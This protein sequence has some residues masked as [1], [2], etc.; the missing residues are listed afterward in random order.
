MVRA[1][2][3]AAGVEAGAFADP[4]RAYPACADDPVVSPRGGDWATAELRC[5]A[6]AWVRA[7]RTGAD[8]AA[9]VA[10]KGDMPATGPEVVTLLRSLA[11]GAMITQADVAL[12]PMSERGAEDIF[13][14]PSAVIGRR[15]RV[16][17]GEGQPVLLRQLEPAW[18]V[19]AGNPLV[20]SAEAGGLVVSVPGEALEDGQM[21]DVIRVRNLSSQREVKAVVTGTNIV[22]VQTNMR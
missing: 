7:L 12:R 16:S 1:A 15:A 20:V 2:M 5:A 19:E 14:D 8:P 11:R 10:R 18:L 13:T 17:L 21:G 22:T 9:K 3:E 6:P 4:V